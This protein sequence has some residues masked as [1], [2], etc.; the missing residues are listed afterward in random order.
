MG[1]VRGERVEVEEGSNLSLEGVR[2][3]LRFWVMLS[4]MEERDMRRK[5]RGVC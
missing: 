4:S 2:R 1:C 3:A 5:S